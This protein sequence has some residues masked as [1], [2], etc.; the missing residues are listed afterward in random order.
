MDGTS[1]TQLLWLESWNCLSITS[2][3]SPRSSNPSP[4]HIITNL[5][6]QTCVF[7]HHSWPHYHY[8]LTG[9]WQNAPIWSISTLIFPPTH[10]S[11]GNQKD[12]C[13]A[14]MSSYLILSSYFCTQNN[15]KL[16]LC[17]LYG[18]SWSGLLPS[19][20]H[21]LWPFSPLTP[22]SLYCPSDPQTQ[23]ALY[24]LLP[25]SF[26]LIPPSGWLLVP[27]KVSEKPLFLL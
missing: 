15:S 21:S 10:S 18:S 8:P 25:D 27:R 16:S 14:Q 12:L 11:W 7:C 13:R 22:S 2:S 26:L 23:Q 20:G 3:L 19:L 17:S 4:K 1:F 9:L 24:C 6:S 5:S